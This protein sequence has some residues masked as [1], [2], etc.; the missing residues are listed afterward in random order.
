MKVMI[1][2]E[3]IDLWF[4]S[5]LKLLCLVVCS[6]YLSISSAVDVADAAHTTILLAQLHMEHI[7]KQRHRLNSWHRLFG[8][9]VGVN[10]EILK[11]KE[12][13]NFSNYNWV[14]TSLKL[15]WLS[16]KT[17]GYVSGRCPSHPRLAIISKWPW[18]E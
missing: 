8:I 16:T 2:I 3:K 11:N 14:D 1:I 13:S 10:P 6:Y 18:R 12:R 17:A 5:N 4:L 7:L 15:G 9:K